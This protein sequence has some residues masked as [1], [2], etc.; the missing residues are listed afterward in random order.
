MNYNI[1]ERPLTPPEDTRKMVF[2]CAICEDP[3]REGDDYYQV[4]DL[5]PCCEECIEESRRY[6]AEL[7]Y[8]ED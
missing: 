8:E 7:D 6:D 3:I 2:R 4:P 5:G 1:P